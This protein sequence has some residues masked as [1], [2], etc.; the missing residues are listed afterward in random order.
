MAGLK[1]EEA[2][3]YLQE[4]CN[5]CWIRDPLTMMDFSKD[6]KKAPTWLSS[7]LAGKV[8]FGAYERLS[9]RDK[10][11][12]L[13]MARLNVT[14]CPSREF[15]QRTV[16]E[17][18]QNPDAILIP[19]DK[20]RAEVFAAEHKRSSR[21]T[22]EDKAQRIAVA[23]ASRH[24][25]TPPSAHSAVQGIGGSGYQA[26][27]GQYTMQENARQTGWSEANEHHAWGAE[28]VYADLMGKL[29]DHSYALPAS[30]PWDEIGPT[31]QRT[32][33]IMA[34]ISRQNA[35]SSL[36]ATQGRAWEAAGRRVPHVP[37]PASAEAATNATGQSGTAYAMSSPN[38][39]R[40][41]RPRT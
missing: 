21:R 12:C 22:Q 30:L 38:D 6:K 34:Y 26:P 28:A 14:S 9:V 39:T 10:L 2:A 4:Y 25:A 37:A 20:R 27:A 18:L 23:A 41:R 8:L 15:L 32:D 31:V 17:W 29:E 33:A 19:H 40:G 35:E 5:I 1:E 36:H 7:V 24:G 13:A 11:I 3:S 16:N